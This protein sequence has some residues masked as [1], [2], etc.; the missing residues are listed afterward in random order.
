MRSWITLPSLPAEHL[1]YAISGPRGPLFSRS[2]ATRESPLGGPFLILSFSF[3]SPEYLRYRYRM[4][5]LPSRAMRVLEPLSVAVVCA[6]L[7]YGAGWKLAAD[8]ATEAA[9]FGALL[10]T[11]FLAAAFLMA[12][13]LV[14][15]GAWRE[16]PTIL[17]LTL[18]QALELLP[19][20]I[21]AAVLTHW[22][23]YTGRLL[24]IPVW[25]QLVTIAHTVITSHVVFPFFYSACTV[26]IFTHQSAV[27][28][29]ASMRGGLGG[30]G[31]HWLDCALV[32][33]GIVFR[34]A[35]ALSSSAKNIERRR[36]GD[37]KI[38]TQAKELHA[39]ERDLLVNF[40]PPPVLQ[41]VQDR[42]LLKDFDILAW[43]FHPACCL[44]SDIV[45]F[46]ALGSR[47]SA[48]Q[49]CRCAR[50]QF[51]VGGPGSLNH[52]T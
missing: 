11:N 8:R 33:Y 27:V 28:A 24:S 7:A 43:A 20:L 9:V 16:M 15:G 52:V 22:A 31:L 25:T 39:L 46:T 19:P 49:L 32:M 48:H 50:T 41:A 2:P 44:Q 42:A 5:W 34:F 30:D 12:M 14:R 4:L 47:I 10:F 23:R 45:G 38:H 13:G 26:I 36:L 40:L 29:Y 6:W 17:N 37:L 21:N 3:R 51:F 1:P 35:T 18:L